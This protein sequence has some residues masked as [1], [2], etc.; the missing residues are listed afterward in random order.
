MVTPTSPAALPRGWSPGRWRADAGRVAPPIRA[1]PGPRGRDRPPRI[2][3]INQ[4]Y[5]PD[6]AST[7]QHLTDLAESLASQGYECHVVCS[8]GG[9]KP[10]SKR[11]PRVQKHNDVSIHRI[12]ATAFGRASTTRRMVDYLSFYAGA[13]ARCLALGRFDVVVTLTTPPLIGLIG[14]IL[15][16]LQGAKHVAWSMDLHPDASIALGRMSPRNPVVGALAALSDRVVRRADTVVA[17]GPYMADRLMAKGVR[18]NRLVEIPVW[19]RADEIEPLPRDGHPLRESL[20]LQGKFIAMYS[21]NLGL[22]HSTHEFIEAARRLR[23]RT[24]VVFLF[25]GGGPRTAE[26]RSA[27]KKHQLDNI[28]LLDYFP[29]NQLRESLSLADAHLVSMRAE[30]NGIVV[31]G[32]LYGAMASGRPVLF[33]GPDHCE[34]ADAIRTHAC[35]RTI[36]LGDVDGLVQS[37]EALADDP[38]LAAEIGRAARSAFLDHFERERSCS[39]WTDL[40]RNLTGEMRHSVTVGDGP[41]SGALLQRR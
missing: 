16:S 28:Q 14:S 27:K 23:H 41:R 26:I 30:M 15:R 22:A 40:L 31:P 3:F 9:Y 39:L 6:H 4:Y 17:L 12:N 13:T 18:D 5:W 19:S 36:R 25:V 20:G 11:P 2:L 29:R 21:G 32:K 10:G 35:G 37:I 34:T 1:R 8:Q 24:D 38:A 33:V 7:A